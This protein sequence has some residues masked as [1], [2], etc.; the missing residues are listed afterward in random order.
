[1]EGEDLTADGQP[2]PGPSRTILCRA[3]LNKLV[4][5]DVV[6]ILGNAWPLVTYGN[7][8]CPVISTHVR[9]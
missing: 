3:R 1:M 7:Q 2:E 9:G 6:F 8:S 5:H 4:K